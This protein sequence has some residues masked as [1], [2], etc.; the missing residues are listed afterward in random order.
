M[1][2]KG[3]AA[4]VSGG[5]SGLGLATA[6]RL[7]AA[8]AAVVLL[9]LPRKDGHAIAAGLPGTARYVPADVCTS[10]SSG[11]GSL[12]VHGRSSAPKP[13]NRSTA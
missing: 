7:A 12:V 10:T 13:R 8:G 4:V 2:I 3:C 9:N 6:R 11:T 5:A 1:Q